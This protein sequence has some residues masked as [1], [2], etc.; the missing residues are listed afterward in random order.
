M[1]LILA[2]MLFQTLLG[3]V[4]AANN[5]WTSLIAGSIIY[6]WSQDKRTAGSA[7]DPSMPTGALRKV[8]KLDGSYEY[9]EISEDDADQA[10][11]DY[12]TNELDK[13]DGPSEEDVKKEYMDWIL[14]R[15]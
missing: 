14:R 8:R 10:E 3:A 1:F 9:R 13:G 4:N 12:R 15:R 6:T 2:V 7:D 11:L 5:L